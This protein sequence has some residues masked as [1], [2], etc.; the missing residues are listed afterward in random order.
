MV[1]SHRARNV[2]AQLSME[3]LAAG[4]MASKVAFRPLYASIESSGF[5]VAHVPYAS[6]C[7]EYVLERIGYFDFWITLRKSNAP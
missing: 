1:Q 5:H 2:V 3:C 6:T 7:K 4:V